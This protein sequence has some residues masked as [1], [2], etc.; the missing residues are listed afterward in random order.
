MAQVKSIN[1]VTLH[2]VDMAASVGFYAHLGFTVT[3]GGETASFTTMSS[4]DCHVN[5]TTEGVTCSWGRVI[6]HVDDVDGLYERAVAAGLQPDASPSD[7]P[8]A[9][10]YFP[11]HDPS[12]H[13]LSFAKRL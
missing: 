9:E 6:F 12:G 8:W 13:D 7:A 2:T 11:I 5:L 10:R 4:G 3:F 1:A